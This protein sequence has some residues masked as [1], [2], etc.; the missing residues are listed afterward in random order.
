MWITSLT[1]ANGGGLRVGIPH[2]R[3]QKGLEGAGDDPL[4]VY[5]AIIRHE[6]LSTDEIVTTTNL[7]EGIVRHALRVGME[8]SAIIRSADGRYRV[9]PEAQ[10]FLS[11]L[12]ERKN[13]LYE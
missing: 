11:Q 6:N 1:P 7:A 10:F 9:T 3:Q 13:F 2:L 8:N 5:S 12:L 4:F